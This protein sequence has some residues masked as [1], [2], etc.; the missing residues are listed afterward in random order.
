MSK[1]YSVLKVK[2]INEDNGKRTITGV[3]TTPRLDRDGDKMDMSGAEFTLPFP[4]M[5][6]HDHCQPVGEV[7]A[8]TVVDEE[9]EVVIDYAVIEEEGDLKKRIDDYWI[10]IKKRLVKGLSIGFGIK[11]FE[12]IDGGMGMHIKK[13]D[14]Y[15]LSAVTVGANPDAVITSVKTIKQAFT[16]AENP[17]PTPVKTVTDTPVPK[18]TDASPVAT[19][20]PPPLQSK[21][22]TLVDPNMGSIPLLDGE[23][24]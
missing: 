7:V 1:A 24:S 23:N 2:A 21:S 14:W 4:F 11:E 12:W 19:D 8:A 18:T 17:T 15:E 9:I 13:W 5:W 3:A 16:D 6:Q 22:I 10:L 20:E